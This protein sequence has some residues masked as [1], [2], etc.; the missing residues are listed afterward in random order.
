LRNNDR[1]F[2]VIVG[3]A[4]KLVHDD[5][6]N[7]ANAEGKVL[8]QR[9]IPVFPLNDMEI[10]VPANVSGGDVIEVLSQ[11]NWVTPYG[12]V[13]NEMMGLFE[14]LIYDIVAGKFPRVVN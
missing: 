2:A 14:Q 3:N 8:S 6:S 7:D 5:T 1:T 13:G 12:I 4:V 9:F 10:S 11:Y